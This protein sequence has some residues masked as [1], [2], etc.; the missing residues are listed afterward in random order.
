[1]TTTT[2][3]L[4]RLSLGALLLSLV[5][6]T[7]AVNGCGDEGANSAEGFAQELHGRWF[8]AS[9][10]LDGYEF[11]STNV[12]VLSIGAVEKSTF[13]T[14]LEDVCP[15][16]GGPVEVGA[17]SIFVDTE[18]SEEMTSPALACPGT[19][20]LELLIPLTECLGNGCD[21]VV[22]DDRLSLAVGN[23]LLVFERSRS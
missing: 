7:G 21:Y 11:E 1:M 8:L 3:P 22:L 2:D 10:T 18:P 17:D 4:R 16:V 19:G 9:S 12:A 23:G 5:G 20:E 15:V 13:L 14:V 6:L